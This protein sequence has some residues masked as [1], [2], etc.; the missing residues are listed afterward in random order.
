MPAPNETSYWS[1]NDYV[2]LVAATLISCAMSRRA[3]FTAARLASHLLQDYIENAQLQEQ[4]GMTVETHKQAPETRRHASLL[5]ETQ[6]F[7]CIHVV[8]YAVA[9]QPDH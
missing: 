2:A 6:E 5:M 3:L 8:A 1:S 4:V 7:S 9:V